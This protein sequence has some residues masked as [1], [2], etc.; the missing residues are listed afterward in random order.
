M[1]DQ[2]GSCMNV[3]HQFA[4]QVKL[5][6]VTSNFLRSRPSASFLFSPV[7][8][9]PTFFSHRQEKWHRSMSEPSLLCFSGLGR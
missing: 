8:I 1:S 7:R 9:C 5:L 2:A 6:A 3:V 4:C